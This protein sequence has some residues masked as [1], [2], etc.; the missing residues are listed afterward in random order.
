M[1]QI[2]PAIDIIDGKCVRLEQG[3]YEKKKVYDLDPLEVAK[4]YEDHGLKNLH[5]VD[6]D[7][8]RAKH[9]VNYK[10]LQHLSAHTNLHIDY[11]GGIKSDE[12][13]KIIFDSGAKQVTLG[14][15]AVNNKPLFSEW[16]DKYTGNRIIL[17]ADVKNKK[18]AIQGWKKITDVNVFDFIDDYMQQ[19]VK[20]ILCTDIAKDGM[21]EGTS[22][23]LY[24]ELNKAFPKLNIIAS[25]GITNIEEIKILNEMGIYGV[26]IGK[27]FYEGRIKLDELQEYMENG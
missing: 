6:L 7:G 23:E 18:I 24:K 13:I 12:D 26:I 3:N 11:G 19:G 10:V 22:V 27:A 15:I 21:L 2:I 4:M 8:A 16:L 5:M 9:V 25:G 14:S 20:Y 17:G 1:I